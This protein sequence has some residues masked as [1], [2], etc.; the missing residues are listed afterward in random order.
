MS[1]LNELK[2]RNVIRVA[3]AYLA[4]AWLLLQIAD[5]LWPIYGL[6]EHWLPLLANLLAVGLVPALIVAWVF[7]WTPDGIRRDAG[8]DAAAR[9]ATDARRFDRAIIVVLAL[10]VTVLVI[11]RFVLTE[12]EPVSTH[13]ERIEAMRDAYGDRSIA[14]LEFENLSPE[15]EHEYF[16]AG[17]TEAI[18]DL[19]SQI[20]NLRVLP[21]V[22]GE[23][24]AQDISQ[25]A[26]ALDVAHVLQ[27]SVRSSGD[28]LR[29]SARLIDTGDNSAA[30]SDTY[31]STLTD[32]FAVQ[33]DIANQVV[34][35][36][37]VKLTGD[38]LQS[39]TTSPDV[40]LDY[41]RVLLEIRRGSNR[42]GQVEQLKSVLARDPDYLPAINLLASVYRF[43]SMHDDVAADE[44]QRFLSL[45]KS[46]IDRALGLDPDN[47]NANASLAWHLLEAEH[48]LEDAVQAMERAYRLEPGNVVT[49]LFAAAFA[50]SI[51][52]F[53][54]AVAILERSIA[55]DP[56]CASCYF[57][58]MFAD[59]V[60]RDY[61][62]AIWAG[63]QRYELGARGGWYSLGF[64]QLLNGDAEAA[65]HSFD[66]QP[67]GEVAS[68][69]AARAMAFYSLGHEDEFEAEKRLA[70]EK[71]MSGDAL[72]LAKLYAWTGEVDRAFEMLDYG[73][74]HGDL[75]I[76]N[77]VWD[78]I[79]DS[80]RGD[81]RWQQFLDRVWYTD[82]ELASV[83][84]NI[85]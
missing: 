48:K 80:L 72:Y 83:T 10:A 50:R 82:D 37:E 45:Q 34:T 6:P 43:Q 35:R 19:L 31:D 85:P 59:Y 26:Q 65:L 76:A 1:F 67:M 38:S 46:M 23:L 64:A 22:S 71:R 29:V 69:H 73:H 11:D 41:M 75:R 14:V 7:E 20:E 25:V 44:T 32:I 52:H 78:P 30:W 70:E 66:Q 39:W 3:I 57:G 53:D 42:P 33:D 17:I 54:A 8:E 13:A 21:R 49:R 61:E 79:Y 28:Q 18:I 62:G 16:A 24:A 9:P 4:G 40:Y 51:G 15:S 77:S 47:A 81:A 27:G 56:A 55:I 68:W 84:L 5:V 36:L 12:S 58:L 63:L 60:R 2:R 74:E